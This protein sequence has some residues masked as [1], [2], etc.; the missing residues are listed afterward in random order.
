MVSAVSW[1]EGRTF[2]DGD[3]TREGVVVHGTLWVLDATV[4]LG[5]VSP[6]QA[7]Q[8]LEQMLERGSRLPQTERQKRLRQ[9]RAR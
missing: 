6:V 3:G 2:V 5:V 7:A 4:R 9:W 1:A 8:A